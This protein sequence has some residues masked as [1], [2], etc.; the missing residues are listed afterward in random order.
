MRRLVSL[1]LTAAILCTAAVPAFAAAPEQDEIFEILEILGWMT[2]DSRGSFNPSGAVT[3][4]ALAKIIVTTS[5][6]YRGTVSTTL[7]TSPFKDVPYTHWGAP[8]ISVVSQAGLMTGYSDGTFRP[9]RGVLFEEAVSAVLRVLGYENSDYVGG[10]PTGQLAF[11]ND[12]ELTEG[13]QSSRGATITRSAMARLLYNALTVAPKTGNGKTYAETLGYSQATEMLQLSD[14]TKD[15]INGP[16]TVKSSSTVSSLGLTS[17][18]V[19]IDGNQGEL[20]EIELYDVLYY[21]TKSNTIWVYTAKVTGMLEAISPN[22]EAPTSVTIAGKVYELSYS[23]ARSVFGLDGLQTGALVTA[24]LDKNGNLYDAY[25]T[26]SLYTSQLGVIISAGAKEIVL[27][28]GKTETRYYVTVLLLNGNT[29]EME[30]DFN[31][32]TMVGKAVEVNFREGTVKAYSSSGLRSVSG[33]VNA[34]SLLWGKDTILSKN[35]NILEIDDWGN[36]VTLSLDRLDGVFLSGEDVILFSK[37]SSGAIDGIILNN[38]C[39][40]TAKYG[41]V[42]SMEPVSSGGLPAGYSFRYTIDGA[43]GSC[44]LDDVFTKLTNGPSAFYLQNG[45]VKEIR[46]LSRIAEKIHT[47]NYSY[48]ET[49][50]GEKYRIDPNAVVY[51]IVADTRTSISLDEAV[52]GTWKY[53][54]YY[55]APPKEGGMIRMLYVEEPA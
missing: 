36:V 1:L 52:S 30:R 37:T 6:T 34:D 14:F 15:T 33:T 55:D 19:Y 49:E 25:A 22:R 13:V 48:L 5:S 28:G 18:A 39:G 20:S 3:R 53:T 32:S 45:Q 2:P 7:Q 41:H 21:S 10:Y 50:S 17:P 23:N 9:D 43:S 42:T 26:E 12:L 54:A 40:D 16:L 35:I 47:V 24:L 38:V 44:T 4:A 29:V 11:A 51:K 31:S 46:N 27:G 8:Y